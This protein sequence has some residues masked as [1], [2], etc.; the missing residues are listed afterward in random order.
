MSLSDYFEQ[1]TLFLNVSALFSTKPKQQTIN[2]ITLPPVI[3]YQTRFEEIEVTQNVKLLFSDQ[4]TYTVG[5][6]AR[7]LTSERVLAIG[8]SQFVCIG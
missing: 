6:F 5:F 7:W 4:L 8:F 2:N 1:A 3:S